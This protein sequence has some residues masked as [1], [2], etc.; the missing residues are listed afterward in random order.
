MYKCMHCG[1]EF[2]EP[3]KDYDRGTGYTD[4]ECP[5]C[6]SE[7]FEEVAECKLCGSYHVEDEMAH[8][9]CK[10]CIGKMITLDR[11]YEYGAERKTA[12]ELNGLLA[13]AF[14]TTEIENILFSILR[15]EGYHG[16]QD[17]EDY[18]TDDITDFADWVVENV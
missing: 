18:C 6:G 1:H 9:V 16:K 10:T 2:D 11:A 7:D 12:V 3:H 4:C 13:Y 17:A 5:N 8:G 15:L 14:S